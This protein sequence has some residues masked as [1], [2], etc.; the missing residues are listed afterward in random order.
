MSSWLRRTLHGDQGASGFVEFLII[1]VPFITLLFVMFELSNISHTRMS[2]A[3]GVQE[4]LIKTSMSP[5]PMSDADR[6]KDFEAYVLSQGNASVQFNKVTFVSSQAAFDLAGGAGLPL[7]KGEVVV[8]VQADSVAA[9]GT[10]IAPIGDGG[11]MSRGLPTLAAGY[12]NPPVI[13]A[14]AKYG[15]S[16]LTNFL[17]FFYDSMRMP[18]PTISMKSGLTSVNEH[19]DYER[20]N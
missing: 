4:A 12:E 20:R 16:F 5:L 15:Y 6:W 10:L 2:M 17:G 1:V 13:I 8:F 7:D 9:A 18:P 19:P 3:R 14:Q 11:V